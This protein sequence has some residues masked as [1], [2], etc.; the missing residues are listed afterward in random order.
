MPETKALK[1][2]PRKGHWVKIGRE[3]YRTP[4][5]GKIQ[6][7]PENRILRDL[8]DAAGRGRKFD[9]NDIAFRFGRGAY[10]IEEVREVYLRIGYSVGGIA[11]LS[12]FEDV[13]M[14]SCCWRKTCR[15]KRK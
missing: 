15:R 1:T 2:K 3:F 4:M 11:E 7:M 8:F 10:T 9:F 12:Y 13:G 5:D 14:D 6:R